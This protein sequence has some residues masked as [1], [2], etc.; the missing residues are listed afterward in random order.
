MV[1]SDVP[2]RNGGLPV[3]TLVEDRS[4]G[5]DVRRHRQDLL[6]PECL[7]GR[8]VYEGVPTMVPSSAS[9]Q[10]CCRLHSGVIGQN[11]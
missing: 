9:A 8:Q 6:G 4:Q 10:H 5:P 7:L 11:R 1:S 2:A 3:R